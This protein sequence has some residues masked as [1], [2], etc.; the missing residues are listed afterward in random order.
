MIPAD[1]ATRKEKD[2]AMVPDDPRPEWA[3]EDNVIED[4]KPDLGEIEEDTSEL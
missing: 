4:R 3:E 1:K 2:A